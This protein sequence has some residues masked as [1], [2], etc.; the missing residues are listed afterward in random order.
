MKRFFILLVIPFALSSARAAD[1]H[2]DTPGV[3]KLVVSDM[4]SKN[5]EARKLGLEIE[6]VTVISVDQAGSCIVWAETNH[7]MAIKYRFGYENGRA[8]LDMLDM[9]SR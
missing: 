3:A 7:E 8:D 1:P 2:C 6:D 9:I 5:P 4:L